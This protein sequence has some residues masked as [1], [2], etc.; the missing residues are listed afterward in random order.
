MLTKRR[1]GIT[2]VALTAAAAIVATVAASDRNAVYARIDKVVLEPGGDAPQRV[3]VWGTFALAKPND[4]NYYLDP[5]RG[6]L[7]F[8]LGTNAQAAQK[9]WADLHSVAGTGQIVSFG[10]R[11]E[12]RARVRP[13]EEKPAN[14]DVYYM[15][16]GVTK[17][18]DTNYAPVKALLAS[19][20]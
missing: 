1:F 14:P 9:E 6:Y 19:K 3:Q 8:T 13:A 7:Y 4:V 18:H 17:V 12:S 20:P 10:S 2:L 16:I 15:N 5:A 11:F